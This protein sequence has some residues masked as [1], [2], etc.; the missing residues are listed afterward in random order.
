VINYS[1]VAPFVSRPEKLKTQTRT[2][3]KPS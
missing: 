3:S 2:W 1:A